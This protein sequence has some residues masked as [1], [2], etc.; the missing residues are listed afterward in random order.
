MRKIVGLLICIVMCTTLLVG[1]DEK[2][3]ITTGLKNSE[4]FKIS[5]DECRLSEMLL[6]LMTEKNR[7]ETELGDGIWQSAAENA[8]LTLEDEIKQKVKN[9]LIELKLIEGFADTQKIELTEEEKKSIKIAATEYM[10]TLTDEQKE[11]MGVTTADVESLYT[12]FYKSEKVY[13]KF[14]SNVDI[15]ISDEEARVI[16]VNY[17]F[18]ATCRLDDQNNKIQY[19]EEELATANAKKEQ[20]QELIDKGNDFITLANQYSDSK[21]VSRTFARGEMVEAFEKVAFELQVG[22]TSQAVETDDGYYF[23]YCVSDYLKEETELKKIDKEKDILKAEYYKV[24]NPYKA[25]QTLEFNDKVWDEIRLSNYTTVDTKELY[26]IYN[27][28]MNQ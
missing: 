7:Y 21:S 26:S 23:I 10:L 24:Y 12:S 28:H 1:C 27:K 2:I 15:E 20:V 22:Q 16:K 18:I 17:I 19:T 6:V 8:E 4:I 25:E 9:E 3:Y 5:G 11:L 14:T 13:N